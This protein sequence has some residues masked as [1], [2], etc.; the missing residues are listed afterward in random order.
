MTALYMMLSLLLMIGLLTL[1]VPGRVGAEFYS[2]EDRS[3]TVHFVDDPARIPR[4]YRQKTRVRREADDDLSEAERTRKRE[5]AQEERDMA[6]QKAEAERERAGQARSVAEKKAERERQLAALTTRV[7]ISG[8]QVFVPV[9][10]ANGTMETEAMLLLDTGATV[11]VISPEV[12][13]RLK[14]EAAEDT[15]IGVVGGR[16]LRAR[17][18]ILSQMRVGPVKRGGQEVV[19][20]RQRGGGMGDGLLGMSF[21][22][23]LKYTI[24][25]AKQTINWVPRE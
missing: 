15:R 9:T 20:V 2:Y 10:L 17:K 6:R 14:I 21:L 13:E 7:V 25:F 18:V 1:S 8:R 11:S 22:G 5:Q 4:E 12:A 3:G 19:I 23:G 16:V 24:D